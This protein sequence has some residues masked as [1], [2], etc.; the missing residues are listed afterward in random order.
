MNK[1][2]L[3][4][5]VGAIF[6]FI[7]FASFLFLQQSQQ[8]QVPAPT[9]LHNQNPASLQQTNQQTPQS[10]TV[11]PTVTLAPLSSDPKEATKQFY[12][13]YF[14]TLQNPLADGAYKKNPYLSDDLKSV[15]ESLY[16]NG[17]APLFCPQNKR[18]N[19]VVGQEQT[20][21][22]SNQYMTE[23][24]ISEASPGTKDLYRVML[25]NQGGKWLISDVNCIY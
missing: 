25:Q 21:Y 20:M 15:M 2:Y 10:K 23:E 19:V 9:S 18:A 22:Y 6:V 12:I 1:K 11:A 5:F 13:Y 16:N 17:N 14:S 7:I 4:L 8:N 3:L 24:T